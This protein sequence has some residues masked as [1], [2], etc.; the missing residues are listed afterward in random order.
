MLLAPLRASALRAPH[1]R[2]SGGHADSQPCAPAAPCA[3][4]TAGHGD[5]GWGK[6]ASRNKLEHGEIQSMSALGKRPFHLSA[7]LV[8]FWKPLKAKADTS[9]ILNIAAHA[10]TDCTR[11]QFKNRN[12]ENEDECREKCQERKPRRVLAFRC[13]PANLRHAG[14]SGAGQWAARGRPGR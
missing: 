13:S 9:K 7:L 4:V 6:R 14:D 3:S 5:A 2:H 11:Q 1:R 12:G 10:H 8:L